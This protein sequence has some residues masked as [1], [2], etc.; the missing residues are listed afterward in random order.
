MSYTWSA[1]DYF[2][3]MGIEVLQGRPFTDSDQVSTLG[4][5]VISETAAKTLWPGEN[6][7][8]RRLRQG[9]LETW[10]TVVGVVEDVMQD[11]FRDQP[12]ALVYF[13]FVGQS[14]DSRAI[15]S[16]AYVVKTSRTDTI[17]PE[18]RAAVREAS[19]TA[20]MYRTYTMEG[21][22]ADSMVIVSFTMLTLGIAASLA[23]TLG[24]IGLFGVLSYVVAE[25]TREIGVRM[26][27]GAE[28]AKVRR[29][30]V[31]QGARLIAVGVV[32]GVVAATATSRVLASLLF[33]VQSTDLATFVGMSAALVMTGLLASYLPARRASRVDPIESLRND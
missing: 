18:I 11:S 16:P 27:L 32:V 19:P 10:E 30:V 5:I 29:M 23:L 9:D 33:G 31:K 2:A 1:G 14:P 3:T 13:P 8:G 26:A 24:A 22:A 20:P 28:A 7:I 25:R 17:G 15:S 6:P 4:N 21:L 12:L